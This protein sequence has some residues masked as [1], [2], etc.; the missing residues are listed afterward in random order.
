MIGLLEHAPGLGRARIRPG[1]AARGRAV[2]IAALGCAALV[3][4]LAGCASIKRPL[5][6]AAETLPSADTPAMPYQI[7]VG[8]VLQTDFTVDPALDQQA[9]VMP[10][11]RVSFAYA[12]NVP[13]AGLTLPELRRDV[14]SRA[15][16]TDPGFDVV[17]RSS[18]GTRVYVLGEVGTPGEMLV[19]G[20]ISAL[21]AISR[22]G[23][24]K[25]TAQ[26][27]EVLL[28]RRTTFDHPNAYAIN[29]AAA[30]DG[31]APED[32][33]PLQTYDVLYVPRDRAGNLSEVFE[34]IRQAVPFNFSLIYGDANADVFR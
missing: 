3:I 4:A 12:S 8:D 34:R 2:P 31:T 11:G 15:G 6:E 33:V 14:A 10:D 7:Q 29:L 21:Q 9:V 25:L 16:I 26:K 17:L 24:F 27:G 28:L 32:D 13:A 23:G 20:N 1:P 5:P 22:A 18:I 30:L 19:S